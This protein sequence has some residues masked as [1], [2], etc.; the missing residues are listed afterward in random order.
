[1]ENTITPSESYSILHF[2]DELIFI[3]DEDW[4]CVFANREACAHFAISERA[5]DFFKTNTRTADR[6]LIQ[7]RLFASLRDS[8]RYETLLSVDVQGLY[9]Q[10]HACFT[11]HWRDLS[12]IH[13]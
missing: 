8:A 11:C 4:N 2:I 13:I 7:K 1:M 5:S 12:L 3:I 10:Y 9:V 6:V